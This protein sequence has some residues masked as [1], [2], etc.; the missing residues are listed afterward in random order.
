ML[1]IWRGVAV[2]WSVLRPPPGWSPDQPG[3]TGAYWPAPSPAGRSPDQP[4]LTGAFWPAPS[5]AGRSPD[6]PGLTS[7]YWPSPSP[8]GLSSDPSGAALASSA[9]WSAD[10]PGGAVSSSRA[11]TSPRRLRSVPG[12]PP[13]VGSVS[14]SPRGSVIG[15]FWDFPI[16]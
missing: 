7:A 3:L 4:G 12:T 15:A 10:W 13:I 16:K 11:G 6:Q 9:G 8:V 2:V 14:G 1:V 5:P